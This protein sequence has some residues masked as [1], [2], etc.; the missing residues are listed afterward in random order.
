MGFEAFRGIWR[1][2]FISGPFGSSRE[3][4]GHSLRRQGV[5]VN[6]DACMQMDLGS[7][8]WC[9][10]VVRC[11]GPQVAIAVDVRRLCDLRGSAS[12]GP[13][14]E[15]WVGVALRGGLWDLLLSCT[16]APRDMC[17]PVVRLGGIVLAGY[18]AARVQRTGGLSSLALRYR[19]LP[20]LLRSCG[21]PVSQ[22]LYHHACGAWHV[23]CSR[24]TFH[25]GA[26]ASGWS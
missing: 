11:C 4:R 25:V 13:G 15:G 18:G 12:V 5:H 6:A 14:A 22:H 17:V 7:R 10:C 9:C 26:G 16:V 8:A 20:I 23:A 1:N 24:P 19:L 21:L 3:A 2:S